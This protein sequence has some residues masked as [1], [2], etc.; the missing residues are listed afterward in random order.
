MV[1]YFP[2]EFGVLEVASEV[3]ENFINGLQR[4]DE[5][6]EFLWVEFD[7][8]GVLAMGATMSSLSTFPENS[9][10]AFWKGIHFVGHVGDVHWIVVLMLSFIEALRTEVCLS[11][12]V[13]VLALVELA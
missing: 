12:Q 3:E 10:T 2:C 9:A 11:E 1:F 13:A 5:L 7:L 4:A 6:A 8:D